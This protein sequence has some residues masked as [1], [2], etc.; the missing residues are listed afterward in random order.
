MYLLIWNIFKEQAHENKNLKQGREILEP[1][2]KVIV[3][4]KTDK[5]HWGTIP[6]DV[7]RN[8]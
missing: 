1:E 5:T 8:S 7:L 2:L 4:C 3:H 6:K